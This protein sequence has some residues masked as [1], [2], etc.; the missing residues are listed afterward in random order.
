MLP[1]ISGSLQAGQH[2]TQIFS[3]KSRT[4]ASGCAN[5]GKLR[6]QGPSLPPSPRSTVFYAEFSF[7]ALHTLRCARQSACCLSIPLILN[8]TR[9]TLLSLAV[10]LCSSLHQPAARML[11]RYCESAGG[12]LSS[13]IAPPCYLCYLILQLSTPPST[14][15]K[16]Q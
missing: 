8:W 1:Y 15:V 12:F 14:G 11:F 2:Q 16:R 13:L 4:L 7:P 9:S 3:A 6:R 5:S 10:S